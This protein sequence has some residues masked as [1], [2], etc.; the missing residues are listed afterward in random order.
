MIPSMRHD[1]STNDPRDVIRNV[2]LAADGVWRPT[3]KSTVS[4]PEEGH[5]TRFGLEEGSFWF[6]HRNRCIAAVVSRYEPP[7]GLPIL[8]V[9]GGNG[10]VARMLHG[11]GYRTILVEP[12][13]S[14][15]RN[16]RA[17]GLPGLVQASTDDLDILPG[18]VGA[19]GLF[20][21]IEHIP[22][23]AAALR[24]FHRMLA[25][26]GRVY[27]T[28]PAHAWLWSSADDH[29]GHQ[30]RYTK[31]GIRDLF[32]RCGYDVDFASYYFWPLPLPMLAGR[33]LAEMISRRRDHSG[34][35]TSEHAGKHP[36]LDKLLARE[37]AR[38]RRGRSIP[39][40]A[41]CIVAATK[42]TP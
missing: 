14:G 3:G 16:A 34:R 32:T 41:S 9:G 27:V 24:A 30:R 38:L 42:P 19:I 23:D 20:D 26:G 7:H 4:Y 35:A 21:V 36:W 37:E 39:M 6:A 29:A 10:F 13:D 33:V 22:D 12:G 25:P 40:G 5:D 2:A 8:D 31:P 1:I 11:M 28:V 15:I 18:S 17:R